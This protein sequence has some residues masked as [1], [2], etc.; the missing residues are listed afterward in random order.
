MQ[1]YEI[2][3][4]NMYVKHLNLVTICPIF[5][6]FTIH[7][8]NIVSVADVRA[9]SLAVVGYHSAV[10]NVRKKQT[11]VCPISFLSVLIIKVILLNYV[12]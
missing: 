1:Y 7:T 10:Q 8:L 5:L 2:F 3:I 12:Y 9:F 6:D 4:D 11:T